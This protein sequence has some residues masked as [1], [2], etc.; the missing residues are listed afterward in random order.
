MSLVNNDGATRSGG[1][2][3]SAETAL[4]NSHGWGR[5]SN[6]APRQRTRSRPTA[7]PTDRQA[8]GGRRALW[9]L[10]Q[11]L[12]CLHSFFC[13]LCWMVSAFNDSQCLG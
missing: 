5:R 6:S 1:A 7:V 3:E 10:I 4:A 9:F 13:T 2:R 8:P 12:G 11:V